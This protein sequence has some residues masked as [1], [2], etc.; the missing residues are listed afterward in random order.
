MVRVRD[1]DMKWTTN[2]RDIVKIAVKRLHLLKSLMSYGA[3]ESDLF[4]VLLHGN[5]FGVGVQVTDLE[6]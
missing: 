2:A 6:W 5:S 4:S 3:P 1:D